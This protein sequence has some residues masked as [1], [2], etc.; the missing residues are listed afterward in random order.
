MRGFERLH[1]LPE[2]SDG[3]GIVLPLDKPQHALASLLAI[4]DLC[5]RCHLPGILCSD[6]QLL[7]LLP[8]LL[9]S[10]H[11]PLVQVTV[12]TVPLSMLKYLPSS[13]PPSPS[14]TNIQRV[15]PRC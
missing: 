1:G 2:H 5:A 15:R 8:P 12:L 6:A 4:A 10:S 9:L 7:P 14:P 3:P 11:P 13:P